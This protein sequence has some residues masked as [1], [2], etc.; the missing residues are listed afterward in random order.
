MSDVKNTLNYEMDLIDAVRV[1]W[2]GKWIILAFAIAFSILIIYFQ[3]DNPPVNFTASTEI[4]KITS[5][6]NDKYILFNASE[7]LEIDRHTL[8]DLYRETIEDGYLIEEAVDKL[9]FFN[10][11]NYSSDYQYYNAVKQFSS[12]VKILKLDELY[13]LTGNF[14]DQEKFHQDQ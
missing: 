8:F 3:K 6:E 9:N 2:S 12:G 7:V 14:H 5:A 11:N 4:K 10:R 1:L 13:F